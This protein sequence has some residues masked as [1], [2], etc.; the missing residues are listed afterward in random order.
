MAVAALLLLA[1]VAALALG[2]RRLAR[3]P[4]AAV[5]MAA[6]CWSPL[7]PCSAR[8]S[9]CRPCRR[10]S[11]SASLLAVVVYVGVTCC[12]SCAVPLPFA[13]KDLALLRPLVRLAAARPRL[14]A[15]QARGAQLR[16]HRADDGRRAAG[17]GGGRRHPP[18]PHLVRLHDASS[19]TPSSS[20]SR[21]SRRASASAC[22][23]RG[24]SRPSSSQTYAVTSVFH[25]QND[26]ATYIVHLLAVHALRLLL[27]AARCAGWRSPP[28]SSPGRRRVRAHRLALEPGRRRR[29]VARGAGPLLAPRP[30]A[31]AS[32]TGKVVMRR[33]RLVLVLGAGYLLFNNLQRHAA[34]V[35]PGGAASQAE[36][37]KG[38]GAM[39]Q[40]L[41][42]R[43]LQ[44]AGGTCCSAPGR[45]RPRASSAPA[46]TPSA[47]ATCTTG[48]WRPTPTAASSASP[49]TWCS[50]CCW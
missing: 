44:I 28:A 33:G 46:P 7:P 18:S 10:P 50:S 19:A 21:S 42:D 3:R 40:D 25:N 45:A 31:L 2:W 16:R 34:P 12:C 35:P 47:S 4:V 43:G 9:R 48:G 14:G 49:C 17:D 20:A 39:R 41:T 5:L 15:G 36:A 26:L 13:A 37:N 32:R 22:P 11:S 38:S 23:P 6:S 24:C 27:H 30:Q 29:L 1:F 8:R